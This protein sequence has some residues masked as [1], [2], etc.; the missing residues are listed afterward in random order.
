MIAEH[1]GDLQSIAVHMHDAVMNSDAFSNVLRRTPLSSREVEILQW[2]LGQDP[3]GH[4]RHL[5]ISHRTVEVQ[6]APR[7]REAFFR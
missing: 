3:A 6:S 4:R 2:T 5:N 7:A 1:I